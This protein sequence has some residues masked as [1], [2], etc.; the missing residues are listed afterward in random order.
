M[1]LH[2]FKYLHVILI[3]TQ[4]LQLYSVFVCVCV[5]TFLVNGFCSLKKLYTDQHTHAQT[6]R[7][8]NKC[9]R[10]QMIVH[11]KVVTDNPLLSV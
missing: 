6:G 1:C 11:R 4:Q 7:K 5:D 2:M 9:T 10:G 8:N 3:I